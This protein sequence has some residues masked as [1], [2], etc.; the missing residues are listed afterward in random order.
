MAVAY[1]IFSGGLDSLLAARLLMEL[2]VE[3]RLLTFVTPFFGAERA[4]ISAGTIGLTSRAVD[5]T[6]PHLEM[7]YKP[8][9]GFGRF[10]N[11]CI[12]CHALMF[13]E[14]GRIMLAEGGDFLFSGEV[15]GQRPKSQTR[16]ALD[17]VAR[18]SGYADYILRPLSAQVLPPTRIETE[19]L[20]DRGKL[21]GF[22][23][24]NRKPQ[25]RLAAR[26]GLT[27]YPS[28]AG[29]CLLTD[30]AFSRRLQDLAAHEHRYSARDAELLKWGRHLRWSPECKL[31]V[32][33][34]EKENDALESLTVPGDLRLLVEDIP[35]PLG[36]IPGGAACLPDSPD[37]ALAAAITA[38]YSDAPT[39]HQAR[40]L[41]FHQEPRG[42]IDLVVRPK[43]EFSNFMI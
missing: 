5:I 10:M 29:G 18:A 42:T 41:I 33:R 26:F 11:P 15:L 20:V 17:L 4:L 39:G 24:R 8:K 34:N 13:R 28:P 12:D 3:V 30:P 37:L 2:G 16:P 36:L 25:T 31:I 35:G 32:G 9:Y 14:A 7:M 40:V 1:G 38:A 43:A 21:M 27:S 19:G 22:S 23:G 6:G